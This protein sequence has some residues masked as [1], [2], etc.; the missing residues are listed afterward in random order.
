MS[1]FSKSRRIRSLHRGFTLVELLVVVSIIGVLIA[2][3]LPAIQA[4]REAARLLQCRN[5]LKQLGLSLHGYHSAHGR[6]PPSSIWRVNGK[7]DLSNADL[8][9]SSSLA[10]NWVILVLP[11][12]EEKNLWNSFDLS[13]PIPNAANAAARA[14]RL[15]IMLC[16]TDAYN[17]TPYD[18][19]V[20]SWMASLGGNWARGNYAANASLGFLG[21]GDRSADDITGLGTGGTVADGGGWG[22]RYL[23]GVMGANISLRIKDITDGASKTILVG[24]LRAGLLPIDTRGVWAMSGACPSA[25]WACGYSQVAADNGP[26]CYSAGDQMPT[27]GLLQFAVGGS[28]LAGARRLR[29]LG[30]PCAVGDDG[31]QQTARSMHAG[32]VNACLCDGSVHFLSEFVE[33]G[34]AGTPPNCLG[35]WD[36]LL[37]SGDGQTVDG[38]RF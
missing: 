25:L 5:N 19:T 6:F 27:C 8:I 30:M 2:Q 15:S 13:R 17:D 32:G 37:L 31:G 22:D 36:K 12:L 28:P 9:N 18:G 38:S 1:A 29:R 14:H 4:S 21:Y 10:E 23:R 34:T 3:L 26:N 7:L 16:P 20:V 11:H 24:E 33:L 35:I